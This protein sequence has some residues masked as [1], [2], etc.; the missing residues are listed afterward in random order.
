MSSVPEETIIRM[1]QED[2][3]S[4]FRA[5]YLATNDNAPAIDEDF[6]TK[7]KNFQFGDKQFMSEQEFIDAKNDKL[8]ADF[9]K[10]NS[11]IE[12]KSAKMR[13]AII[14]YKTFVKKFEGPDSSEHIQVDDNDVFEFETN[15][16]NANNNKQIKLLKKTG[17]TIEVF[18]NNRGETYIPTKDPSFIILQVSD[19]NYSLLVTIN[20]RHY[21]SKYSIE[22]T[23]GKCTLSDKYR[24]SLLTSLQAMDATTNN[25]IAALIA[26]VNKKSRVTPSI[27]ATKE[28]IEEAVGVETPE[29]SE[30]ASVSNYSDSSEHIGRVAFDTLIKMKHFTVITRI[31][32][33]SICTDPRFKPMLENKIPN[34]TSLL[35][36]SKAHSKKRGARKSVKQ[37]KKRTNDLFRNKYI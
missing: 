15:Y 29:P 4:F 16:N 23:T 22:T 6:S 3:D 25:N 8:N 18:Q 2:G 11:E 7:S 32:P 28:E 12:T 1:R 10:I 34:P 13:H 26:H 5:I 27:F 17:E 21:C 14:K 24:V 9:K 30:V 31:E 37:T 19:D 20:G 35:G 33:T 36:G